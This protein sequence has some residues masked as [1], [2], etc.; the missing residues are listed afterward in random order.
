[1]IGENKMKNMYY[2]KAIYNGMYGKYSNEQLPDEGFLDLFMIMIYLWALFAI[3]L[4]VFVMI[5]F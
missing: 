1:M 4:M 5:L 3:S 2:W